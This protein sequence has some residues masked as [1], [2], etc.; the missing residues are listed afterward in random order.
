MLID[1]GIYNATIIPV[2]LATYKT[3]LT[4]SARDMVQ[5]PIYL[6]ICNLR[7]EIRK[8]QIRLGGII[9]G[10]IP[11]YKRDSLKVKIKIYYQTIRVIIKN[12]F[13]SLLLCIV[14]LI[15]IVLKKAVVEIVLIICA[16]KNI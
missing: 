14:V 13:K 7:H 10:L 6:T 15:G 4:K 8:S 12:I 3:V 16:D 2:L 1:S 11:I 5:W 9:I